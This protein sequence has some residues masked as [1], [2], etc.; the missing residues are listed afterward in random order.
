MSRITI[1]TSNLFDA[2]EKRFL[3]NTSVDVDQQSGTI[4]KLWTRRDDFEELQEDDIDLRGK[5]V[6]PGFVDAHTHIFLH[7]YSYAFHRVTN[8]HLV[9][10]NQ[11]T[12][13]FAP[14]T[15]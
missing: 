2:K 15:G 12:S 10:I 11:A 14:K 4:T 13:R 1:H 7:A 3:P 5:T 9:T 8:G 6:L